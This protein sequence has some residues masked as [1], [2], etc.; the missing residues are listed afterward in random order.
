[1]ASV[2]NDAKIAIVVN[3]LRFLHSHRSEIVSASL[4]AGADVAIFAP[5]DPQSP[6]FLEAKHWF[7]NQG[8]VL[9]HF[10]AKRY[11]INPISELLGFL[12]L[13]VLLF[14]FRP[15][16]LHAITIKAIL[17]AGLA[18][19]F[20][21]VSKRLFAVS[22]LGYLFTEQNLRT[23]LLRCC[24]WPIYKLLASGDGVT[25]IFQNP[26]DRDRVQMFL[27]WSTSRMKKQSVILTGSGVDLDRFAPHEKNRDVSS[28]V[29]FVCAARLIKSKGISEYIQVATLVTAQAKKRDAPLPTFALAGS[30]DETNQSA[31]TRTELETLLQHQSVEL[32]DFQTDMATF[33]RQFDVAVL[34][35]HGEGLPKALLEAYA[36]GLAVV[37][38][39]VPG[40]RE[41]INFAPESTVLVPVSDAEAAAQ[42]VAE[43]ALN[44]ERVKQMQ[45]MARLA[46]VQHFDVQKVVNQHLILYGCQ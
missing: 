12:S 30:I 36:S 24:V 46:A 31:I 21:S 6:G 2:K 44:C 33:L 26:D 45:S 32:F 1:V 4:E 7:E 8:A 41:L 42:A 40:C 14:K 19:R 39:D 27:S 28:G 18:A 13:F 3:D 9:F 34:L 23:K 15:T 5:D 37:T 29:R 38:T 25:F 17:S 10:S 22:G 16:V 43:L 20:L 11:G 35:S